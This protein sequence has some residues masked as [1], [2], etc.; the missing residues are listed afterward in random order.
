MKDS[1]HKI[2]QGKNNIGD[3]IV[4]ENSI[5][6]NKY[7]YPDIVYNGYDSTNSFPLGTFYAKQP[8]IHSRVID[9]KLLG[10]RFSIKMDF[11]NNLKTIS[12]DNKIIMVVGGDKKPAHMV[13]VEKNTP[14][15]I[16]NLLLLIAYS[17]IFQ[18]PS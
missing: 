4:K 9:G 6:P 14:S 8:I 18:S 7:F 13:L 5:E 2:Y 11:E 17:E 15:T 12:L 3:F 16:V 1:I 10:Q